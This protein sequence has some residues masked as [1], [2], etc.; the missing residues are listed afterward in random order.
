[1]SCVETT[2][3]KKKPQNW[4]TTFRRCCQRDFCQLFQN[5]CTILRYLRLAR[6]NN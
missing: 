4:L 2:A 5:Q 1:M 3:C 6:N